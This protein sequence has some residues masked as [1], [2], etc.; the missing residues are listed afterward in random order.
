MRYAFTAGALLSLSI[1]AC[2]DHPD[3]ILTAPAQ[4]ST[5][6]SVLPV[7]P[8]ATIPIGTGSAQIWPYLTD[9][10][11]TLQDP[12]NLVFTGKADPRAI[13]N[14]L[15][16]LDGN[17]GAPFPPVFPFTCT[18]SDAIG[19][20]MAGFGED[21][22]WGGTAVQLQ[23]GTYGPIRFHLRLVKLGAFT[24]G[25]AHFEV[26][27][28][29][30]TE[31]Q[32]LSWELA[33]QLLTYDIAR[34]GLL[35]APPSDAGAINAA[36]SHRAI[37]ALIYN[38]LPVGLR[39]LIGGP[40]SNV[41]SDVGI[42]TDGHATS[43]FLAGQAAAAAPNA[44]QHFV[45]DFNQII[46]KP[47]CATGPGDFLLVQGPIALDQEVTTLPTGDLRKV[48]RADGDLVAI[49]FDISSWLPA[50]TALRAKVSEW[51]DSRAGAPGGEVMGTQ[52]QQLLAANTPGTGQLLIQINVTPGKTPRFDRKV[53]C[54]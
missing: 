50:G 40:L 5:R 3:G 18:W 20:L 8:L 16:G 19:G 15:L 27:I 23:C 51:Q 31:H 30:T 10:L 33:E 46:P 9:N 53:T 1:T 11:E 14:A 12:V 54:Q 28:P 36:P 13:R 6:Q 42:A 29:G 49:P 43:F 21:A 24:I 35:G 37:P 17:R 38:G 47:F 48:V 7:S 22:G 32:V 26:V 2:G 41:T 25:N 44:S 39:S 34:T 45:I 52:H 4:I